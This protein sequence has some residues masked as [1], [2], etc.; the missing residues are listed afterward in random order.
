MPA[1]ELEAL[2]PLIRLDLIPHRGD[3]RASATQC[4]LYAVLFRA[5]W[6][7]TQLSLCREITVPIQGTLL[8]LSMLHQACFIAMVSAVKHAGQSRTADHPGSHE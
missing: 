3:L 4:V 5:F 8:L 6:P 2:A 7:R 1:C